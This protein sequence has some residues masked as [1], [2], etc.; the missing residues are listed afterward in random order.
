MQKTNREQLLNILNTLRPAVA[1]KDIVEHADSFIFK[2]GLAWSYN[3]EIAISHPLPEGLDLAGAVLAVPLLKLL[4]KT[5]EEEVQ[6]ESDEK[7]IRIQTKNSK[8]GIPLKVADSFLVEAIPM[9][10]QDDWNYIPEGMMKALSLAARS[11]STDMSKPILTHVHTK[12][13]L[14]IGC[15]NF[16]LTVCQV[17]Q[18]KPWPLLPAAVVP[19][20]ASFSPDMVA[21][22]KGWIH[23]VNKNDCILSCRA[24][25]GD[26]PDVS[27]ILKV[28][29]KEI[30]FPKELSAILGRAGIFSETEFAS[31][32]RVTL[33]AGKGVLKVEGRGPVGWFEET[34]PFESKETFTFSVHP[35]Y[36]IT[37]MEFGRKMM[38]GEKA[39]M[40]KGK[41]FTHVISI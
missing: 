27:N 2:D 39:L 30:T 19:H 26:Y 1:T 17:K 23:F 29:G 3:D 15:N 21:F 11:A 41:N 9:P 22:T 24:G 40:L 37:A 28:T 6:L 33:S 35:E 18:L 31:D 16:G 8:A 10:K 34:A 20:L 36:I 5:T 7:E 14:V 25:T 12:D 38:L 4:E 13:G 32:Q